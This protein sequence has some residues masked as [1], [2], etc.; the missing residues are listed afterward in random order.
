VLVVRDGAKSF[1]T[2][3]LPLPA[4]A[5][6]RLYRIGAQ[7]EEISRVCKDQLGVSM[8][9]RES[10]THVRQWGLLDSSPTPEGAPPVG[11]GPHLPDVSPTPLISQEALS[12]RRRTAAQ[13]GWGPRAVHDFACTSP[14]IGSRGRRTSGPGVLGTRILKA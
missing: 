8:P 1:A 13:K 6:R 12:E 2:N 5:V 11:L 14:M 7:I 10:G 9:L 3:R 4:A